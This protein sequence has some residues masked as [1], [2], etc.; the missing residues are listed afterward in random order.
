MKLLCFLIAVIPKNCCN[1][2]RHFRL[3]GH[4]TQGHLQDKSN[5]EMSWSV[6]FYIDK[7]NKNALSN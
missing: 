3:F 1:F 6:V 7:H 5:I 4:Q 2:S